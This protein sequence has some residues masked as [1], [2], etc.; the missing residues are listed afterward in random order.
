MHFDVGLWIGTV[1]PIVVGVVTALAMAFY[2][3]QNK[4]DSK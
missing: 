1:F 4:P 3:E 2:A